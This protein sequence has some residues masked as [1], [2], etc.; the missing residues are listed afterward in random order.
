MK[1]AFHIHTYHSFDCL[2]RPKRIISAAKANGIDTIIVTDHG[3]IK[4]AIE[5]REIAKNTGVEVIIGAEYYS[6]E[7]DIIGLFLSDEIVSNDYATIL[8]EIIN[9]HL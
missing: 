4:G 9:H 6:N 8:R 3:T 2:T 1:L 7:G 5:T